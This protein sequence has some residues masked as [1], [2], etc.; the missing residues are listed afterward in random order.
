QAIEQVWPDWISNSKLEAKTGVRLH[1]QV[2]Q[3]TQKLMKQGAIRGERRGREW[4]F[5]ATKLNRESVA[6]NT[7]APTQT[8]AVRACTAFESRAR[9]V[10]GARFGV[11]LMAGRLPGVPKIF[12]M[13]SEDGQIVGDAKYLDLVRGEKTPPAKFSNIAEHVWLLEKVNAPV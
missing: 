9:V 10:L 6:S 7:E 4:F 5:I 8:V 2:F 12:D 3:L 11:R 1:Q 13:V